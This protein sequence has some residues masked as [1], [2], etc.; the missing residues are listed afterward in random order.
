[1]DARQRLHDVQSA[2]VERGLQDVK[3]CFAQ[4]K[5][6]PLS[7]VQQDVADAL[8]AYKDKKF[9]PLR[10]AGDSRKK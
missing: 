1:M 5:K 7:Y 2:L 3:F 4:N 8:Q 9:H 6:V 10:K